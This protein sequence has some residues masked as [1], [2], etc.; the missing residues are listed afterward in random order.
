MTT[1]SCRGSSAVNRHHTSSD[2]SK[3]AAKII[4]VYKT[5]RSESSP[6]SG[7]AAELRVKFVYRMLN[8]LST[9]TDITV[10]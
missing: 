1:H 5:P 6:D 4:C 3:R 10:T 8:G 2:E 7:R 9:A